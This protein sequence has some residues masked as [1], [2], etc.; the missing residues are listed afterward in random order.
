MST[1]SKMNQKGCLMLQP[2]HMTPEGLRGATPKWYDNN[3][4]S[5]RRTEVLSCV[6]P[7][8]FLLAHCLLC[9]HWSPC[10]HVPGP[11]IGSSATCSR[12]ST[13]PLALLRPPAREP[14]WTSLGY[15]DDPVEIEKNGLLN[16]HSVSAINPLACVFLLLLPAVWCVALLPQTAIV[17]YALII[18]NRLKNV[19]CEYN[20]LN[21]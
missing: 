6:R 4:I 1:R 16:S 13:Y 2:P 9:Y 11:C 12:E 3:V 17:Y 8:S 14:R 20:R 7:I 10:I 18:I 15:V 19:R 21:G 5:F